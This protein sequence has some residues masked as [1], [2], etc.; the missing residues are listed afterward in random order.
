MYQFNFFSGFTVIFCIILLIFISTP[1]IANFYQGLLSDSNIEISVNMGIEREDFSLDRGGR[2]HV[3]ANEYVLHQKRLN[4]ISQEIKL[5]YS[6]FPFI[7]EGKND[8]NRKEG[9]RENSIFNLEANT[10]CNN[11]GIK[12]DKITDQMNSL[13][14][15]NVD[16]KTGIIQNTL[17]TKIS[18]IASNISIKIC[19]KILAYNRPKSLKRLLGSLLR[20]KYNGGDIALEVLIDGNKTKEVREEK[21]KGVERR[22]VE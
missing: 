5:D 9:G 1:F 6:L 11:W 14:H 3:R 12:S 16:N 19:V 10:E 20:A 18:E 2:H 17:H 13:E 8:E 22:G 15:L 21:R 7:M 4:P